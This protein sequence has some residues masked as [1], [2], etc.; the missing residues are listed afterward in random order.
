MQSTVCVLLLASLLVSSV[1]SAPE[2]SS[3]VVNPYVDMKVSL[4][5]WKAW[6]YCES[7]GMQLPQITSDAEFNNFRL[8]TVADLNGKWWTGGIDLGSTGSYVWINNV[9]SVSS[10]IGYTNWYPGEPNNANSVEHCI[11]MTNQFWNDAD[12]G[13]V[14]KVVCQQ[15]TTC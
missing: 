7:Q 2:K 10:P 15:K 5:F 9:K 3:R 4:T 8:A 11:E 13:N 1:A 14:N 6:R 12:C